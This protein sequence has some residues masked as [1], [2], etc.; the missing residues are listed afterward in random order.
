MKLTWLLTGSGGNFYCENCLRDGTLIQSLREI[1]LVVEIVPLYLPPELDTP[2]LIVKTPVFF[3]GINVYLQQKTR[4]FRRTPRWVDRVFDAGWLL[5]QAGRRSAATDPRLLGETTLSMLRGREGHQIKEI[6]RLLDWIEEQDRGD[7]I[8]LSN[9]LLLGLAEPLRERLGEPVICLLQDEDEFIDELPDPWRA[10]VWDAMRCAAPQVD[11]FVAL[12]EYYA[13]FMAS[14]LNLSKINL[15]VITP[16]VCMEAQAEPVREIPPPTVGFLSRMAPG[17]GLDTLVD[18]FI[19]LRAEVVP[20]A[21]LLLMG[22]SDTTDRAYVAALLSRLRAAGC[23]DCVTV[24]EDFDHQSRSIFYHQLTTLAVPERRPPAYRQ[25]ALEALAHGVPVIGPNTGF[26]PELADIV[27]AG[28]TC[29]EPDAP[30][31]LAGALATYLQDP[32]KSREDGLSGRAAVSS[33]L[34]A[35]RSAEAFIAILES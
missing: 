21:R 27:G 7:G 15:H 12:S 31:L 3:G 4:L 13:E 14:R 8:V 5:T 1:G 35:R 33:H 25:G 29:V 16:G 2:K 26:F 10:Q 24:L 9:A 17:R 6:E 23:A 34:T 19:K 28:V 20:D 11:H 30:D 22:G 32:N 18:A